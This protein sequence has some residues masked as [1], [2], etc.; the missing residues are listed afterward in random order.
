MPIDEDHA[1][2]LLER[3][4]RRAAEGDLLGAGDLAAAAVPLLPLGPDRDE[5]LAAAVQ[6]LTAAG[7]SARH[8]G[9]WPQAA[10][11][12]ERALELVD[13]KG[14]QGVEIAVVAQNLAVAYKYTGRFDDA[15][16]LYDRALAIAE[17]AGDDRLV[18]TICHNLGGL[19]HA[20][21][22]AALGV[23]WAR[24]SITVRAPFGDPM[25][26]AADRGALA[27]LLIDL[28]DL[29]EAADNLHTARETFEAHGEDLEV[30]IVDGNLA[31]GRAGMG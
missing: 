8:A 7:E 14:G 24:R 30:A 22:D 31:T 15:A 26:L 19:A 20:R 9:A 10:S 28:G 29:D 4:T 11:A 27:G 17:A 18:A 1:A 3:A 5:A 16:R 25:A 2:E 13:A 21:G 12:H 23:P 6:L